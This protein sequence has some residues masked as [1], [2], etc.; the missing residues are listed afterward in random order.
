MTEVSIREFSYNPSAMF[1]RVEEGEVF[2]VTRHGRVIAVLRPAPG[3]RS[4]VEELITQGLLR[5]ST[6]GKTTRDLD[7][8]T[9]IEVPDDVDPLAMLLE[10][11]EEERRDLP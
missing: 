3:P 4:R 8:Y 6:D 9:R 2:E 5:D 1:A 10:M 11:R 7:K